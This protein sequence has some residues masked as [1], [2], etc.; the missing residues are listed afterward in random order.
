MSHYYSEMFIPTMIVNDWI[1]NWVFS[2]QKRPLCLPIVP[3][4]QLPCPENTHRRGTIPVQL[5]SYLAI[6]DLTKKENMWLLL[7]CESVES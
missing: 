1:E 6:L 4:P 7:C 2:C 3:Q 5:V